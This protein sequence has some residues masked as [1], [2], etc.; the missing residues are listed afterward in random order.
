[1]ERPVRAG[2]DGRAVANHISDPLGV[3]NGDALAPKDAKLCV[4]FERE[5]G[6]QVSAITMRGVL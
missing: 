4:W 2:A 1:M 6:T 5:C 3:G